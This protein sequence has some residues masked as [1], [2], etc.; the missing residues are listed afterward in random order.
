MHPTADDFARRPG[1]QFAWRGIGSRT[2][3]MD[4]CEWSRSPVRARN[5]SVDGRTRRHPCGSKR[6]VAPLLE[7]YR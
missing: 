5:A 4:Y 7:T 1:Q 3:Q 2:I 6:A